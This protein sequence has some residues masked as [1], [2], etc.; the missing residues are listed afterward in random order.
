MTA[1][2]SAFFIQSSH[3]WCSVWPL[4]WI[5]KST[6]VVVPPNAAAMRAGLEVVGRRRA[7]ERHVEVRV[8]VD[9]A[10]QDVLAR[11]RR[12]RGRPPS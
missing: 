2:P 11:R 1:L 12:S 7:A 5:A 6:M 9:A 3:A 8:D 4:Y 10:R